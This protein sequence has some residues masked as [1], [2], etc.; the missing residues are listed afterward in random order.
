MV[1]QKYAHVFWIPVFPLGKYVASHAHLTA[2]KAENTP[3]N[4]IRFARKRGRA[5]T[6]IWTFSDWPSSGLQACKLC[7]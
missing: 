1:F 4:G 5:R 7:K 6:P 2:H 3:M